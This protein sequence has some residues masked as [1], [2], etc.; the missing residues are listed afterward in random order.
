MYNSLF[1]NVEAVAVLP[2]IAPSVAFEV[3]APAADES[4]SVELESYPINLREE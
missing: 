4:E 1:E 3:G 2:T